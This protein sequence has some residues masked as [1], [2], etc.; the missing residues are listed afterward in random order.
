MSEE[1]VRITGIKPKAENTAASGISNTDFDSFVKGYEKKHQALMSLVASTSSNANTIYKSILSTVESIKKNQI[2]FG[3][4]VIDT[5]CY[6]NAY[7]QTIADGITKGVS[8]MTSSFDLIGD[9]ILEM[10]TPKVNPEE[11]LAKQIW[12][13]MIIDNKS[14][15]SKWKF[16]ELDS[17]MHPSKLK[18]PVISSLP[19]SS[20]HVDLSNSFNEFFTMFDLYTSDIERHNAHTLSTLRNIYTLGDIWSDENVNI[21]TS[22]SK[23]LSN[24]YDTLFELSYNKLDFDKNLLRYMGTFEEKLKIAEEDR[25]N[26]SIQNVNQGNKLGVGK[27][28][29]TGIDQSIKLNYTGNIDVR[30]IKEFLESNAIFN[31]A[32]IKLIKIAFSSVA[33]TIGE[34]LQNI[35]A[36]LMPKNIGK[37]KYDDLIKSIESASEIIKT[38]TSIASLG[39][40]TYTQS[41]S[42]SLFGQ[43][44]QSISKDFQLISKSNTNKLKIYINGVVDSIAYALEKIKSIK[45]TKTTVDVLES[46]SSVFNAINEIISP[47]TK[48]TS[49]SILGKDIL[50]VGWNSDTDKDLNKFKRNFDNIITS[51]ASLFKKLDK[52]NVSKAKA[53]VITSTLASILET[54]SSY[55]ITKSNAFSINFIGTAISSIFKSLSKVKIDKTTA[56]ETITILDELLSVF[57]RNEISTKNASSLTILSFGISVLGKTLSAYGK[58]NKTID[59]GTKSIIYTIDELSNKLGTNKVKRMANSLKVLSS[60]IATLGLSIVAFAVIAPIAVICS[61]ALMLFSKA[62]NYTI[63]SK[64]TVTGIAL[65]TTSLAML[66]L[67]IW[68]FG[69]VVNEGY[70]LPVIGGLAM[71]AGAIWLFAGGG[72]FMGVTTTG[73]PPYKIL[74]YL[75]AGLATL[76][77]AIW[78]WQEL[79]ITGEGMINV[80]GG[81]AMLAGATWLFNK[82]S[83]TA[84]KN[85]AFVAGGVAAL[86]GALWIWDKINPSDEL[87]SR[88]ITC[89]AGIGIAS[90]FY[91]PLKGKDILMMLGVAAGV[92]AIGTSM[93]IFNNV[94]WESVAKVGVTIAGLGIAAALMGNPM[95]LVGAGAMVAVGVGLLGIAGAFNIISKTNIDTDKA[96]AF[97]KSLGIIT[98]GLAVLAI[99]AI[100]AAATATL[101][102]PVVVTSLGMA[103]I[104]A[105]LSNINI[106]VEKVN[107]FM[108][109]VNI[110]TKGFGSLAIPAIGAAATS[111]LLL[112]VVVTSLGM[113]G[114]FALLSN[115]DIKVEKVTIFGN[116][117]TEI[118]KIYDKLGLVQVT[119]AAAKSVILLPLM[120]SAFTTATLIRIIS[121]LDIDK[122]RIEEN[123][124]AMGWFLQKMVDVFGN[125]EGKV[126]SVKKGVES[127]GGLANT[128]KSLADAVLTVSKMEYPENKIVD[129]KIVPVSIRKLTDADFEK[130]ADGIGK[131]LNSLID[132]LI[133]I[134]SSQETYTLGKYTITNPFS[135]GNKVSKGIQAIK[136]IGEIFTPLADIIKAIT[137]TGALSKENQDA[138]EK[139]ETIIGSMLSSIHN[140]VDNLSKIKIKDSKGLKNTINSITSIFKPVSNFITELS[141]TGILADDNKNGADKLKNT[142][143]SIAD[144]IQLTLDKL[145][146]VNKSKSLDGV[147]KN[148]NSLFTVITKVDATGLK[149]FREEIDKIYEKLKDVKPWNTFRINFREYENTTGKLVKHINGIELEKAVV[150]SGIVKDLKDAD[151]NGNIERLIEQIKELIGQMAENQQQFQEAQMITNENINNLTNNVSTINSKQETTQEKP[152][153]DKS[154]NELSS[155]ANELRNIYKKLSSKL[156]VT[157][158]PNEVW[159]VKPTNGSF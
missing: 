137:E 110:I 117:T 129:G 128:I 39:S 125:I 142:I 120:G 2:T 103:G 35:R 43:T 152:I 85:M 98:L 40:T 157:Q 76:G 20:V 109:S 91:K 155:I 24:V 11:E 107:S 121:G 27:Q 25:Q 106:D 71:L 156:I 154:Q 92:A 126:K 139:I 16:D 1:I 19:G 158:S 31:P 49:V 48:K 21:L 111:V 95:V 50:N 146:N 22:I 36:A 100:P 132:P 159:K 118:V 69:E 131:M 90:L 29:N 124:E 147:T 37:G 65:F 13:K 88:T 55:N 102:L 51:I 78:A 82:V 151:E 83:G 32:R 12:N 54:I 5:L 104:F 93:I 123:G 148:L 4:S 46:I 97:A 44:I 130:V 127:V 119:K 86:G 138:A 87:I 9:M 136:G 63:G 17:M 96:V 134:G 149:S 73:A 8:R 56:N 99:P 145:D 66:G 64:K 33:K 105:L 101:L 38:I 57:S 135:S 94:D 80:S 53:N 74:G 150:L 144:V 52:I 67:S 34:G 122:N 62:I 79:G 133:K 15:I 153:I 89:I 143:I 14:F 141:N 116:A 114:I 75:A 113:A 112:P 61:G 84:P 108:T 6:N 3:S 60:G 26:K 23:H 68:A 30:S 70:L 18:R 59:I 41:S 140:S 45:P 28:I 47:K 115:I 58:A 10:A 77:L 81:I 72:K 7:A 42:N